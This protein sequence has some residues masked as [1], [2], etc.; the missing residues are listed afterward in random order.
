MWTCITISVSLQQTCSYSSSLHQALTGILQA[1]LPH[2]LS[3]SYPSNNHVKEVKQG[4]SYWHNLAAE[5]SAGR[6]ATG[7]QLIINSRSSAAELA[8]ERC[9]TAKAEQLLNRAYAYAED[10]KQSVAD[11]ES[12]LI[13]S[14]GALQRSKRAHEQSNTK[15]ASQV[16]V[17]FVGCLVLCT[18]VSF[19]LTLLFVP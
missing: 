3:R 6:G 12:E 5:V 13:S 2:V 11:H 15:L 19:P 9:K 1:I 10:L 18:W 16:S 14:Q 4:A 17:Y 8:A 7:S